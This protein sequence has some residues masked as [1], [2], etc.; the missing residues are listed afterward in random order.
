MFLASA[1]V[2]ENDGIAVFARI[3]FDRFHCR[4]FL[5]ALR[6]DTMLLAMLLLILI[7][8]MVLLSMVAMQ[9]GACNGARMLPCDVDHYTRTRIFEAVSL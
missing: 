3:D 8:A 1:T 7:R 2:A 4:W 9:F 5:D 6:V